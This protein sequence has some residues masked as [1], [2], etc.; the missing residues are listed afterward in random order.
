[1]SAAG[2]YTFVVTGANGCTSQASAEVTLDDVLPGASAQGGVL[3]CNTASVQLIGGGNG[4]YAWSGPNGF[5]STEQS[6]TVSAAGTYTLVV[7]GA[8]GCTSQASAEV[9]LDD[10]LPGANAQGGVL[11]CNTASVQL[12]G[13]GNGTFAWSGPNGFNSTEQNPTVSAAGTYTLVVTGANGCTSQASAEVTLDDVLPGASAQGGVLNCNTAS[14]QLIGGGNG[15]YAWSGPNGFNSTEQSPTVSAAGT[16]TLVVTGANGCTSQA[17]A[18]VTLDDVLPGASAQGGVLDCNTAS[19]QLIGG[20]NGTFAWSGPNGFNSTVQ[21]PTVSAAGTYTLVVTGANGCTSQASAEVTLDDEL[22]GA[23][24]QG[25]VLN[26]NTASVQLIGGGNGTFAWSGPNGFNSTEQSPTV[27]AAGTYTLVVT[28]ANGCTSQASANVTLDANLPGASALGGV[29]DC[30]S[31]NVTLAGAGNGTYAWSG[32]NG[33]TSADQNPTVN[34]AGT[35]TLVVTGSNGCTS[36]ASATVLEGDCDKCPPLIILCASDASIECGMSD[37]PLDVGAPI[38]RKDESCPEVHVGWTDQWFGGCPW[39]LVRTWTATDATGAVEVC[40]Q[41]ITVVD[42]Q[43][44]VL[45]NVPADVLVSCSQVPEADAEV[46][47]ADGCKET[48]PVTATDIIHPSD[49]ANSY[50]IERIYSSTD[51]CGNTGTAT[52]WITV[53]DMDAPVIS[54]VP[55]DMTVSCDNVPE[56][57]AIT[58]YDACD[59]NVG[60]VLEETIFPGT[61]AGNYKILR[62]WIATDACGNTGYSGYVVDVVDNEGPGFT[63]KPTAVTV[64]CNNIP[65]PLECAVIDNCNKEV[66]VSMTETKTGDGCKANYTIV[67]TY[68]AVDECGN[69]STMEEVIH[70]VNMPGFSTNGGSG[71]AEMMVTAAPNPFRNESTIRFEA[72]E[73]GHAVVEVS[74]MQGRKVG[75]L[76]NAQVSKGQQVQATFRPVENGSGMFLYRVILNNS[77]VRGR[78]LYQP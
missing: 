30:T 77:E 28:G 24:A 3:N 67:R 62:L 46:W 66:T 51:D 55:Q 36:T 39:T 33:F 52:Q 70:V 40:I 19:V 45:M 60:V 69:T 68:T 42:S 34:A 57:P 38:F 53:V 58:V 4:T 26:C 76:F 21:S 54:G 64:D 65:E 31:G 2:T 22:P 27:S 25:G 44:P 18:E 50:T 78:L 47:A 75:E 43:A 48:S 16:Y 72:L 59:P 61:C 12:I 1:V 23:S 63:C 49:C 15:T 73:D 20:G 5:N 41:T 29:L 10:V 35:Y 13:G 14:V 9:T 37:H 8:N 7:T 56:L 71:S 6:P 17:S 11:N 32:P 74:D